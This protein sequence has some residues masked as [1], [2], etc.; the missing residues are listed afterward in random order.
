MMVASLVGV[1]TGPGGA[2]A[3]A[4]AACVP[5]ARSLH[6][7]RTVS[8]PQTVTGRIDLRCAA[9]RA[10]TVR[11][12]ASGGI[13]VPRVVT[14]LR[15]RRSATFPVRVPLVRSA[16]PVYVRAALGG[17]RM[18]VRMGV[19]PPVPCRQGLAAASG[20]T[21]LHAGDRVNAQVRLRCPAIG[22]TVVELSSTAASLG[23]P[24]RV[25]VPAGRTVAT[26]PVTAALAD[27]PAYD[28]TWSAS[29]AGATQRVPVKVRP[30]LKRVYLPLGDD[31]NDMT[32]HVSFTGP[33]DGPVTL[34]LSS[35]RPAI[36]SVPSTYH[37]QSGS[38]GGDLGPVWVQPVRVDTPVTVS[39]R[40]GTRTLTVGKT[41]VAPWNGSDAWLNGPVGDRHGLV[42]HGGQHF[43][44]FDVRIDRPAPEGGLD[45]G[46]TAEGDVA[47]VE[48][49]VTEES[50]SA[51]RRWTAFHLSTTRVT[52]T[53][54]V[55]L[56]ARIGSVTARLP[57][58]VHPGLASIEVPETV[59]GGEPLTGT[60]RLAGPA[61]ADQVVDLGTSWGIVD[62]A[63]S[64]TIPAG[65]TSATF[66]GITST[67]SRPSQV[68]IYGSLG[69]TERESGP[70][71]VLPVA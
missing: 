46:I 37:W 28:A 5:A 22:R 53:A 52:R 58:T 44:Q 67:V 69:E 59:R 6:L 39:V 64:V 40:L 24:R 2:S 65:E 13:R 3:S 56:V 38:Y 71:T 61:D 21:V 29:Y 14:V 55:V 32:P 26:V 48:L 20:P 23:V 49:D 34:A 10:T 66:S 11:L 4:A 17:W 35:S 9:R 31:W 27:G 43:E 63:S 8:G 15:G 47:A 51:T 45:V 25:A 42:M 50:I 7:P 70:L 54:R 57:V 16:R 30:G 33:L 62:V 1:A 12:A 60:V 41:L 68:R 36:V 19:R 18:R